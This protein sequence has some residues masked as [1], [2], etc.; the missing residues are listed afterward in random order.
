MKALLLLVFLGALGAVGYA[1]FPDV[2]R[3]LEMR[4]M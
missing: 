1:V 2:K 4:Q 3:Y